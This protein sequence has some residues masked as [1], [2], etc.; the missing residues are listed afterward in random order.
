MT[1]PNT[2]IMRVKH[3]TRLTLSLLCAACS[4]HTPPATGP[5]HPAA[6]AP[7]L[8]AVATTQDIMRY[9]V[10]PSADA[11]WDSVGSI[12]TDSG[13]VERQPR[14][15]AEWAALRRDAVIL[16]EATNLLVMPDRQVSARE[17][18]SDGP[19]VFSSAE[20]QQQLTGH[21][22]E[23]DGFALG[24]RGTARKVLAAIDARDPA[25]LLKLGE[26]MDSACE[27][28]HL[29]NWYPHEVIPD[30]PKDPTPAP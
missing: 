8:E 3:V 19:G 9:E 28:C 16:V 15:D 1:L 5:A 25:A 7:P 6:A 21:R 26:A 10:D 14:T 4:Q 27:A 13:T 30:L 29:A 17:F 12:T 23:F 18:P 2:I 11:I 20:I 24:L 22:I